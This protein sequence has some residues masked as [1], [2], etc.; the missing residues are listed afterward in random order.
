MT[1]EKYL[2]LFDYLGRPAGAELGLQV[3]RVATH[4]QLPI[5]TRMVSTK[6]YTGKINLYP[7]TFLKDYF[8]TPGFSTTILYNEPDNL[9]IDEIF[10]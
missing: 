7:E 3:E 5:K 8:E 2:S 10:K 9:P 4:L 6:N 1:E